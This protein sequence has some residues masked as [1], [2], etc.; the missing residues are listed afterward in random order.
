M[1]EPRRTVTRLTSSVLDSCLSLLTSA[2][3][4]AGFRHSREHEITPLRKAAAG[5]GAVAIRQ[6]R[7]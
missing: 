4:R 2:A 5:G 6:R 3:T 7:S 1:L